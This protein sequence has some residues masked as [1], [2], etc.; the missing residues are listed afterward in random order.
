[1]KSMAFTLAI[2]ALSFQAQAHQPLADRLSEYLPENPPPAFA[3]TYATP[4]AVPAALA[5]P[6]INW[7]QPAVG[8]AEE[9][10]PS[11][12][13]KPCLDLSDVDNPLNDWP[14]SLSRGE[15]DYWYAHRRHL[16]YC[17][18]HEYMQRERNSPGSHGF[19]SVQLAWMIEK[20]VE[21]SAEKTQAIIDANK[22]YGV[23]PQVLIGAL[24]QES[25]FAE[26]GI[27][28]DGGNFSCGIQQI[29]ISAWCQWANTQTP[30][31]KVAMNW[32][33]QPVDCANGDIVKPEYIK[34]FF[35]IARTRLNGQPTYRINKSHF[36]GITYRDVV[37]KFPPAEGKVQDLRFQ[38]VRSFIDNCSEPRRGILSKA[39]FLSALYKRYVSS[40]FQNKDRYQA[41]EKFNRTCRIPSVD[42]AYPLH[43][44]WMMA[45]AAYNAGPRAINATATYN[46]W[47]RPMFEDPAVVKDFN[48][49]NL[50]ES[51][52]WGG[53]YNRQT[54]NIDF[55]DFNGK[56]LSWIWYKGCVVQRHIARVIQNVT[57]LPK[58]FVN[59]LEKNGSCEKS[60]FNN[61]VLVKS[62]VPKA[63]QDSLGVK[64]N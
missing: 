56:T 15:Q 46:K 4:Y 29:N 3:Q 13:T 12:P 52:Y 35:D 34:P 42:N 17:R 54:D 44:G 59:S 50:I 41:N 19:A 7:A 6:V 60:T 36:A 57:L 51:L 18:A 20:S 43:T 33:A 8:C 28:D 5:K 25:Y 32:P 14:S 39:Y 1:M 53:K 2:V 45:V 9:M 61:G 64:A 22:L 47:T 30:E 63:R 55:T 11:I 40:A 26:L 37:D 27:S 31:E 23:P 49:E 48:P 21:H 62:A 16:S 58:N 24:Y 38:L 10:I